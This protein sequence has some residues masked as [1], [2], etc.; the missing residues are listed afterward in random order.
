MALKFSLRIDH[1]SN[2]VQSLIMSK[3]K[4]FQSMHPFADG[5]SNLAHSEVKI[6]AL[7]A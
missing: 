4:A 2:D 3:Y 5:E 1:Q 6:N 7:H